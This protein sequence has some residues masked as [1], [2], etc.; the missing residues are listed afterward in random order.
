M[1]IYYDKDKSAEIERKLWE[2]WDERNRSRDEYE[3]IT[4]SE[5][6]HGSEYH[7]SDAI[8]CPMKKICQ[9]LGFPREFTKQGIGTML[10][11]IVAQ[12]LIQ[13]LY[14]P[15]ERE[16][17]ALMSNLVQGHI[18]IYEQLRY[19]IE[20]KFSRKRIYRRDDVPDIWINQVCSYMAMKSSYK[21]WIIIVN[22][23]SCQVSAFC[24]E[25]YNSDILDI[26]LALT[27][28]VIHMDYL[29]NTQKYDEAQ[30]HPEEYTGCAY[31]NKCPQKDRCKDQHSKSKKP[32]SP[33][34]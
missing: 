15:S 32:K 25:L 3:P 28:S 1:K 9:D 30:I 31:K 19:V 16:V 17:V 27:N 14:P 18:D 21:G 24:I 33:L 26:L 29:K 11:G 10:V 20:I 34:D 12:K 7:V 13:W 5:T 8:Y 6:P 4:H 23:I 22:L 2:K